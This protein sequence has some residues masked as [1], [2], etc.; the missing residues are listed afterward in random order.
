MY[1]IRL[2]IAPEDSNC[3]QDMQIVKNPP[4]NMD[5]QN[6]VLTFEFYKKLG[7]KLYILYLRF[8]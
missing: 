7:I 3:C 6:K 2:Y 8:E 1:R 5:L 4:Q